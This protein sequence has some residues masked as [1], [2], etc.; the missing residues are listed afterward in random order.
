MTGREE[1]LARLRRNG[2]RDESVLAAIGRV[3]RERFVPEHLRRLA[4]DDG[5][6]PLGHGATVSQPTMVA[7]MC[8]EL[9]LSGSERVLDVGTGSGYAA[10]VLAE[11]ADE[12]VGIELVPELAEGARDALDAAGYD[13]RVLVGD[14]SLGVPEL[15][16]FDAISVAAAAPAPPPALVAQLAPG[17][18][19]VVPV[20]R[21]RQRL[22]LVVNGE[23]GPVVT[24]S[25]ACRFVPLVG[26]QGFDA[27]PEGEDPDA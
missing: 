27:P 10:A 15:A 24:R 12:V 26:G 13:V 7:R 1:L 8:E 17:G 2:I 9:A 5:A 16:P 25:V 11:L 22:T 6:L 3:P 19:L 18:R 21:R 4:Y 23:D 14:G 20:G